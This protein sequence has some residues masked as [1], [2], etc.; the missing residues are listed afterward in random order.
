MLTVKLNKGSKDASTPQ[1]GFRWKPL[2]TRLID[3]QIKPA[4]KIVFSTKEKEMMASKYCHKPLPPPDPGSA[5]RPIRLLRLLPATDASTPLQGELKQVDLSDAPRYEALSYVWGDPVFDHELHVLEDGNDDVV[6]ITNNLSLALRRLR[7]AS[8]PRTLWVDAV[9]INQDDAEERG[10]QVAMMQAIFG[11][12]ECCLAWL[13][14]FSHEDDRP[15]RPERAEEGY[16]ARAMDT[17]ERIAVHDAG[18][19]GSKRE[20]A[21]S[22]ASLHRGGRP[23]HADPAKHHYLLSREETMMLSFLFRRAKLWERTWCAQEFSLSPRLVLVAGDARLDWERVES[24]LDSGLRSNVFHGSFGHGWVMQI[25]GQSFSSPKRIQEQR[26]ILRGGSVDDAATP[27]EVLARFRH[28]E[29]ADP[30]DMVFGLLG[31]VDP[32]MRVPVDYTKTTAEVFVQT[33]AAIINSRGD[34]DA[35]C[36]SPWFSSR[37][38][39]RPP[40]GLPSWAIDFASHNAGDLVSAQQGIFAAGRSQCQT[41]CQVV[42]GVALKCRGRRFGGPV[43]AP[44]VDTSK[45]R[46][47]TYMGPEEV[48]AEARRLGYL[49]DPDEPYPATGE[50]T[51]QALWRTLVMDCTAYP[52]R[53]LTAEQVQEE[54]KSLDGILDEV[55]ALPKDTMWREKEKFYRKLH[56]YMMFRR[57]RET[58]HFFTTDDGRFALG[59]SEVR[60]GDVVAVLDG[61][62][63][64]V[65]LRPTGESMDG[66]EC[67]RFVS[68]AYV[69]GSMD[70]EEVDGPGTQ[71]LLL[72]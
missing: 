35:V 16:M 27:M 58:W 25:I 67:C 63:V 9:C 13:G 23:I 3:I 2:V 43:S 22:I 55:S 71:D 12:C 32:S 49:K 8:E 4:D 64:P 53:R 36:Q 59:G 31:L 33:T 42:D 41:P 62:K 61:A 15:R 51:T 6:H 52:T 21:E 28:L 7:L 68:P 5:A 38:D 14:P 50:R 18:F 39:T 44:G 46:F 56:S 40:E 26:R 45:H 30:R 54:T 24:F 1:T 34:L 47:P 66:V 72:V 19:L 11:A 48:I 60:E 69:H 29:S 70:G 65:V 17:F 20:T 37:N 10:R 57:N